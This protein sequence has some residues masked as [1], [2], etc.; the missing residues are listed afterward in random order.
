M[1][2]LEVAF[3]ALIP[4]SY[5]QTP[6]T[7]PSL[8]DVPPSTSSYARIRPCARRPTFPYAADAPRPCQHPSERGQRPDPETPGG[9]QPPPGAAPPDAISRQAAPAVATPLDSNR[10]QTLHIGQ[11]LATP[12]NLLASDTNFCANQCKAG[13]LG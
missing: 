8:F 12:A 7:S 6:A 4:N 5:F 3:D 13:L 9:S 2:N 10:P 1:G 11:A